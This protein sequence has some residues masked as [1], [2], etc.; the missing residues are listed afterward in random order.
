MPHAASAAQISQ[1]QQQQ[2]SQ[3]ISAAQMPNVVAVQEADQARYYGDAVFKASLTADILPPLPT[4]DLAIVDDGNCSPRFMRITTYH[5]PVS[6]DLCSSS[7]IPLAIVTQPF[8]KQDPREAPIP[9]VDFGESGPVRCTRCR[10]YINVFVRFLKGGRTFE[11]NICSINN[12]VPEDYFCN[13]D[14]SGRRVD[15]ANR[16]ELLFGSVDFAASKEYVLRKPDL[17]YLLF[18]V[19]SSRAA[20]QNG[21]FFSSLQAIRMVAQRHLQGERLYA[22]IALITFDKAIHAYDL[23]TSE[24]QILV[25]SDVHEPF[26]PL[27][28]GLFFDPAVSSEQLFALLDRLPGLYN[29][30]RVVD[31]CLGAASAFALE[32][33][34]SHGGRIVVFSTTLPS[35]G[36][37]MLRNRDTASQGSSDKVN[38]LVIP[39]GDFYSKTAKKAASF[40]VSY[41]LVSTPSAFM[42][43]ATIGNTSL[44]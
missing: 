9:V 1:Q 11:C 23:R 28:D 43:L 38:P 7:R 17:P 40:G 37:G 33:M 35:I 20:V 4:T 29:E 8:A 18:A 25:M 3:K 5:V 15:I 10:A 21:A 14:A 36:I 6:E 44:F 22:K 19:D 24:A 31:S 34:Q 39:Q 32:A 27:H 2:S 12:D 13:I 41:V 16:P 26:V 30:T 42:D